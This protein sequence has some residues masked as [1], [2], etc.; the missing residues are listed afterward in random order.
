MGYSLDFRRR[1][2]EHKEKNNLTFKETSELFGIAM[3]TLFRWQ[4]RI[5]PCTSH[6]KKPTKIH[7]Q[8]LLDDIEKYPDSYHYERAK[9]LNVSKS[10]IGDALKRLSIT[11]KKN[12]CAQKS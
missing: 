10:G 11:R 8:M 12:T 6:N 7:T 3:A 5:E 1:I 2:F 4:N 9:R